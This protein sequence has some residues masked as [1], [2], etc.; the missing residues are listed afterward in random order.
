MPDPVPG[1]RPPK[2]PQNQYERFTSVRRQYRSIG[3]HEDANTVNMI[4]VH[5]HTIVFRAQ[6][7]ATTATITSTPIRL[8]TDD[9]I[10]L[11]QPIKWIY[12]PLTPENNDMD[13]LDAHGHTIHMRWACTWFYEAEAHTG[14]SFNERAHQGANLAGAVDSEQGMRSVEYEPRPYVRR[15]ELCNRDPEENLKRVIRLSR[16]QGLLRAVSIGM[17]QQTN[18]HRTKVSD[19]CANNV[20]DLDPVALNH[21]WHGYGKQ[22]HLAPPAHQ[23]LQL[24][25]LVLRQLRQTI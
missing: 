20:Q 12:N 3:T 8:Y 24:G 5:R 22:K 17:M 6:V 2:Y 13:L 9:L 7:T 11:Q 10:S 14:I 23:T 4:K 25:R 21:F 1:D 18:N 19:M 16:H 15:L